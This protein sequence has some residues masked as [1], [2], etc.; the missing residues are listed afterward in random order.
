ML[1]RFRGQFTSFV[2]VLP[3]VPVLQSSALQSRMLWWFCKTKSSGISICTSSIMESKC[4]LTC[5]AEVSMVAEKVTFW[6]IEVHSGFA[7]PTADLPFPLLV[8]MLL[9]APCKLTQH[10]CSCRRGYRCT[11]TLCVLMCLARLCSVNMCLGRSNGSQE[12]KTPESQSRFGKETGRDHARD[13]STSE[14][15]LWFTCKSSNSCMEL[16]AKWSR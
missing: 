4:I 8:P 1:H 5:I 15:A 11:H 3:S 2:A 12:V 10:C 9:L 6:S 16:C 13:A 14:R 7:Q